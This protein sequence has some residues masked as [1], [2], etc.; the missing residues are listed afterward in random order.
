MVNINRTIKILLLFLFVLNLS[1]SLFGPLFALYVRGYIAGATIAS[2]GIAVAMYSITKSLVQVPLA[3]FLDKSNNEKKEYYAMIL[4]AVISVVYA[5][6]LTFISSV[7]ELYLLMAFNGIG[8]AFLMAA[9]YGMFS[10]H[11]DRKLQ[12]YEWSLFSVGGLTISVAI[13]AALGGILADRIGF[14]S[15]LFIVAGLNTAALAL[16]IGLL[17]LKHS[18]K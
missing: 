5:L 8:G 4:G 6:G 9:Y 17:P 2:V 13:G 1:E 11:V 16:L 7:R 10:H 15:L 12:S 18:K 14:T 3:R